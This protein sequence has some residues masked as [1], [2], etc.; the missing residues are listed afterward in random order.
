MIS[1]HRP[2]SL[3][4]TFFKF[5]QNSFVHSVRGPVSRGQLAYISTPQR[6][7]QPLFFSFFDFFPHF[8]SS[9]GSTS[10]KTLDFQGLF[11]IPAVLIQREKQGLPKQPL[12]FCKQNVLRR[13]KR[14][15]FDCLFCVGVTYFSGPSPGKYLRR[16][17]A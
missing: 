12:F 7:S 11:H 13:K 15:S 9:G 5:F 2:K 1:Y 16:K 14:Q 8:F 10:Q 3:S 17:R 6:K 4:S